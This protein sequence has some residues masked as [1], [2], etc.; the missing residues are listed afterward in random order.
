MSEFEQG[1]PKP[2]ERTEPS[3]DA[4]PGAQ[5]PLWPPDSGPAPALAAE[6][7]ADSDPAWSLTDLGKFVLFVLLV[8]LPIAYAAVIGVFLGLRGLFGWEMTVAEAF[9]HAP[10]VVALQTGWEVLWLVFLYFTITVKYRQRFWEAIRWTR[11][12][13]R[14]RAWIAAGAVL[15]LGAQLIF[16]IFPTG[17]ELPIEK[18]FAGPE[19]G[20]VLAVFGI[21]VAPFVEELV[22]RGFFYPVFER[23]WG[24]GPAVLLTALLFAV[25]HAA[26]LWGGWQEIAAIFFVGLVFSYS[27][28]KTGSLVPSYLMHL[29][30]NAALFVSLYFSTDGFQKLNG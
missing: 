22:F 5:L 2:P 27:R 1:T 29:G 13:E 14:P 6:S 17:N 16:Y 10:M 30:Y 18:L 11:G 19:A 12:A 8:S 20:Y 15:A 23:R 3:E 4:E 26:Q 25:I 21:G 28:A 7:P 24:L 9:T